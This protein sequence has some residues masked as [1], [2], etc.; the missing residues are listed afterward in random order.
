MP[1]AAIERGDRVTLRTAESEDV[2][3]LQRG[4]TNPEIRYPLASRVRTRDEIEAALAESDDD[5]LLVCLDADGAGP[6]APEADETR[7]IGVVN[8]EDVDWKRPELS[9]W[10]V[11]EVHGEG[12]GS[13]AVA[14]AVDYVFRTY[15]T[16]AVSARA[17]AFNDASRG[18][19]ES[20]GFAEEGRLRK[21]MFVDGTHVDCVIYGLLRTEW[22]GPDRGRR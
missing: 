18:L 6:G 15:G 7:P 16:P 21:F 8:V 22:D 14:L 12:Y 19:L 20:L 13:E 17:F 2:E 4:C 9:Y 1:G 3:F 11:P 5:R 10:L